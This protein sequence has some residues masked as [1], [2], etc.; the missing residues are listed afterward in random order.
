MSSLKLVEHIHHQSVNS[1]VA[2]AGALVI[3]D[4]LMVEAICSALEDSGKYEE[5][6]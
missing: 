4:T 5:R 6:G 2:N 1:E 3:N